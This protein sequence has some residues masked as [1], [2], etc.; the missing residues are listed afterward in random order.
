MNEAYPGFHVSLSPLSTF[1][2][3]RYLPAMS[4]ISQNDFETLLF[5]QVPRKRTFV[6][7]SSI[8]LLTD[9]QLERREYS[10]PADAKA[11]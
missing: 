9:G 10:S 1:Q 2:N 3:I 7:I 5:V 8:H 6:H 11:L 4:M